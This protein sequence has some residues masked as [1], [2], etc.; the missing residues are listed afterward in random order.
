[1]SRESRDKYERGT[2]LF[3]LM[4]NRGVTVSM[5]F[6]QLQRGLRN[7]N[8]PLSPHDLR[9]HLEYLLQKDYVEVVRLEEIKGLRLSGS[10]APDHIM[11]VKLS[12][13]GVDLLE[14]TLKD[15]GIVVP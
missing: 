7:L 13:R 4:A 8:L 15:E 1:M 11:T 10:E 9:D 5:T 2:I 6:V 12:A 3:H 14:G